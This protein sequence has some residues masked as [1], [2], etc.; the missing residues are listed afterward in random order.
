M[1]NCEFYCT[2]VQASKRVGVPE[3]EI[4]PLVREGRV[5]TNP[6]ETD[7]TVINVHDLR[8]ELGTQAVI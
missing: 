5:R 7:E 6:G 3:G 1:D 4:L 8:N 2:L